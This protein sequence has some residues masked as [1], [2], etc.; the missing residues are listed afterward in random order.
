MP[1]AQPREGGKLSA[2]KQRLTRRKGVEVK[3]LTLDDKTK[4]IPDD[5]SVVVVAH[6][7]TEFGK[8][9]LSVLRDYVRR[10][11]QTKKT[12]DK[13][14]VEV[15]QETVSAGR[16]MLLLEPIFVKEGATTRLVRSGLEPLL[17]D[18]N[19]E[20]GGD[21]ILS[22]LRNP[23]SAYY[24]PARESANPIATAFAGRRFIFTN[25]QT[26]NPKGEQAPGKIV[27]KLFV[28][29]STSQ[30]P[31][32][33]W[34]E[35]DANAD[36]FALIERMREDEAF[37]EKTISREPLTV[38]VAVSDQG[39]GAAPRIPGHEGLT[40]DTPRM[41]VFGTASWLDNEALGGA[42]A[43]SNLD[44][45]TNCLSWAREKTTVGDTSGIESKDRKVY[46]L[47]LTE[48]QRARVTFLPLMIL[49]LGIFG[50]GMGVWIVRRR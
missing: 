6:P 31:I 29:I 40:K 48:E 11:R 5:A 44:L 27:D 35:K 20:L 34:R 10:E 1:R 42:A 2:L 32:P 28:T 46:S 8:K 38:A 3:S 45:F 7:E 21:R 43:A 33:V 49:V 16:L 15:E 47:G 39:P 19:V 25:A 18:Y 13:S 17:G 14:G 12:K 36:P 9:E 24:V 4:A 26:V 23:T 50:T 37:M 30:L 41:V 22:G